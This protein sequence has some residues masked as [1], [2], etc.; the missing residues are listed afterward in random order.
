MMHGGCNCEAIRYIIS[1]APLTAYICH[2]HRCQKR[3]RSAF[4]M[5]IVVRANDF[6]T[7]NGT[8]LRTERPLPSGAVKISFTCGSCYARLYA[9]C[10]GRR[11]FNAAGTLDDTGSIRPVAQFWT[12]SA[13]PWALVKEDIMSYTEQSTDFTPLFE[14]WTAAAVRAGL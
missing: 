5:S 12:F 9:A 1:G 10:D 6:R 8:P 11:T 13:Q 4:S 2:C 3:A 7:T 14:A